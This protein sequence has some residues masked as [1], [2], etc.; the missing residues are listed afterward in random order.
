MTAG[1]SG[2]LASRR[3]AAGLLSLTGAGLGVLA[4]VLQATIGTTIPS[5][6]GAKQAP[7][8]LGL[9]TIG[10][11]AVAAVAAAALLAPI[12]RRSGLRLAAATAVAV[13]AGVCFST[14][15]RLWLVPGPLLLVGAALSIEDYRAAAADVRRNW[16]RVLLAS[17]GGFELLMAAGASPLVLVIGGV[18]GVALIAS[19][20]VGRH[21]ARGA[22]GLMVLGTVPFAAVAWSGIVPVLLLLL[23]AALAVP[24]LSPRRHSRPSQ[25]AA[26]AYPG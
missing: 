15:G 6:T 5:W 14:V 23:V 20:G 22:A 13:V 3:R 2:R 12:G 11:S 25:L 26:P 18:G 7:V 9:L 17:G 4:G 8:A 1:P 10:L 21:A 16:L 24:V 19:A